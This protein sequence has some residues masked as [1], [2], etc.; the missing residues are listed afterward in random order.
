MMTASG[1]RASCSVRASIP[2]KSRAGYPSRTPEPD[3]PSRTL[4]CLVEIHENPEPDPRAGTRAM[5]GGVSGNALSHWGGGVCAYKYPPTPFISSPSSSFASKFRQSRQS[6]PGAPSRTPDQVPRAGS[7]SRRVFTPLYVFP[8]RIQKISSNPSSPSQ[9]PSENIPEGIPHVEPLQVLPPPPPQHTEIIRRMRKK[10]PNPNQPS[11]S[12][13]RPY[14]TGAN[15]RSI[16]SR[17][18]VAYYLGRF[19]C[20]GYKFLAPDLTERPYD[21]KEGE[22]AVY[23]DNSTMGKHFPLSIYYRSILDTYEISPA[24]L[25]PNSWSLMGALCHQNGFAPNVR[26]F[27]SSF[28]LSKAPKD[29]GCGLYAFSSTQHNVFLKGLPSKV[30]NFRRRWCW[31]R[32]PEILDN[33]EWRVSATNILIEHFDVEGKLAANIEEW[34][35]RGDDFPVKDLIAP[36]VLAAAGVITPNPPYVVSSSSDH[37]SPDHQPSDH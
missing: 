25:T 17:T 18:E 6:R 26:M 11:S 13:A 23:V 7:L 5:S 21:E 35:A 3:I 10:K 1:T 12:S 24:Q 8:C 14:A 37:E 16:I 2:T 30:D 19:H 33:P 22:I 36:A 34:V 9:N 27:I 31:V 4:F 15:Q 28:R 20:L 29:D 32:G